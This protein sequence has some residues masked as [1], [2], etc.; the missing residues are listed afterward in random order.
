MTEFTQ[1]DFSAARVAMVDRQ[2]R[3]SDV[4]SYPIID[5][6]L[7]TPRERYTPGPL[8]AVA[9]SDAPIMLSK[10]REMFAPRTFAK[11]LDGAHIGPD[12]LVLDL[13][14]G[15]GYSTAVIARLAAAVIAVE[16]DEAM[17]QAAAATLQAEEVDNVLVSQGDPAAGRPEHGPFDAIFIN[18]GVGGPPMALLSQLKEG[19]RIVAVAMTGVIGGATAYIRS[20]D[21]FQVRLLFDAMATVLPGFEVEQEFAL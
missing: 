9:Y 16:P 8:R 15:L 4:T 3:P 18:G 20:G 12:D 17:A 5:A 21:G 10:G 6:M 11:L 2:V 1:F 7:R 14:P 19:G 13:A